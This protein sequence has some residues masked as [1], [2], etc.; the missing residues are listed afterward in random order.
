MVL[1]L[2]KLSNHQSSIIIIV[3]FAGCAAATGG[4][5]EDGANNGGGQM[6]DGNPTFQK[7][8]ED[9][10]CV[11]DVRVRTCVWLQ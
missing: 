1:S 8:A 2:N 3:A 6:L 10:A 7:W 4:Q 9:R 11:R 5:Q